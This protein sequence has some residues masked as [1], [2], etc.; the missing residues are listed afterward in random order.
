MFSSIQLII[1]IYLLLKIEHILFLLFVD[2]DHQVTHLKI[3]KEHTKSVFHETGQ[4]QHSINVVACIFVGPDYF[5]HSFV[6]L[7]LYFSGIIASIKNIYNNIMHCSLTVDFS[8]F[9][10]LDSILHISEDIFHELH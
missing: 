8:T 7:Y 3:Y 1:N 4:R 9:I 5:A 6:I 2:F 10:Y